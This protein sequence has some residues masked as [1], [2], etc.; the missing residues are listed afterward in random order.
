MSD[1]SRC[2]AGATDSAQLKRLGGPEGMR[3]GPENAWE[4]HT[5]QRGGKPGLKGHWEHLGFLVLAAGAE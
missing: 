4:E 3:R 2:F 1:G 5:R